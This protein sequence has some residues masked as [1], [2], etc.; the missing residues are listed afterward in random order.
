M[1]KRE[2]LQSEEP[3]F[4]QWGEPGWAPVQSPTLLTVLVEAPKSHPWKGGTE[5]QQQLEL[6]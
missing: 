3:G 5:E 4:I 1:K 6:F 2:R